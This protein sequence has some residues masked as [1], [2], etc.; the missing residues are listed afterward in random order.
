[1]LGMVSGHGNTGLLEVTGGISSR[2]PI[3]TRGNTAW[4]NA[5]PG[6]WRA[7]RSARDRERGGEK[8]EG[9]GER[10]EVDDQSRVDEGGMASTQQMS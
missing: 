10:G 7:R 6:R 3:Q 2:K 9:R 8:G 4:A 1:M 5:L